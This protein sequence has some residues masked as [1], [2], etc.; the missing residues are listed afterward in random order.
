M[1]KFPVYPRS[2]LYEKKKWFV[3]SQIEKSRQVS[4][5][6]LLEN[7]PTILQLFT[8]TS[9]CVCLVCLL[10]CSVSPPPNIFIVFFLRNKRKLVRKRIFAGMGWKVKNDN[11]K[12]E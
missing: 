10:N 5:F 3:N 2:N 4:R 8:L 7:M 6:P 1:E 9:V 12:E 11:D